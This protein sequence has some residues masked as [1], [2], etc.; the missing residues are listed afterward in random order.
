[1]KAAVAQ[2]RSESV[3][4]YRVSLHE[5]GNKLKNDSG[6]DV[7]KKKKVRLN[8]SII[9]QRANLRTFQ[10]GHADTFIKCDN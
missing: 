5:C 8:H 10:C 2:F 4:C 3:S 6:V 7:Q 1:M 9:L